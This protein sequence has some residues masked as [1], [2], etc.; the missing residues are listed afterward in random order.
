VRDDADGSRWR[1]AQLA[2]APLAPADYVIEI[3]EQSDTG[4]TAQSSGAGPAA[5]QKRTLLGFRVIP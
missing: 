5:E 4:G 3:T 2:L 1:T